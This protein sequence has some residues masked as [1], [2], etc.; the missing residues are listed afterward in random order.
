[1][2]LLWFSIQR[3]A[4]MELEVS[5]YEVNMAF[6]ILLKLDSVSKLPIVHCYE[7][8]HFPPIL[9]LSLK[10]HIDHLSLGRHHDF[11]H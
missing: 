10:S 8:I 2:W 5:E 6:F 9:F 1:M 4:S 7:Y 3:V 11:V